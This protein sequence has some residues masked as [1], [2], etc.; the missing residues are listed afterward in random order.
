[1]WGAIVNKLILNKE[2]L[3]KIENLQKKYT[4]IT[5]FF[6]TFKIENNFKVL[7][8]EYKNWE[9][10]FGEIPEN[11]FRSLFV[12]ASFNTTINPITWTTK[13]DWLYEQEYIFPWINSQI[14]LNRLDKSIRDILGKVNEKNLFWQGILFLDENENIDLEK[15]DILTIWGD[16]RYWF[17]KIIL[18]EK[19]K[20]SND[21]I[22]KERWLELKWEKLSIDFKQNLKCFLEYKNEINFKWEL[23][24]IPEFNFQKNIPCTEEVKWFIRLGSKVNEDFGNIKLNKWK[25]FLT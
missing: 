20:I 16:S 11:Y 22:K 2:N 23:E 4:R 1:M 10:Y 19:K 8:P 9:L 24:L 17:W 14:D 5:N 18:H 15:W 12:E 25:I 13:E 6:P 3:N 7:F 21:E